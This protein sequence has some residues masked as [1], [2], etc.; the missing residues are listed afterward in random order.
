MTQKKRILILLKFP[1]YGGGSGSFTRNL[2]KQLAKTGEYEVAI[3]APDARKIPGV[4]TYTINPAFKAVFESHPE[5]KRAKRYSQLKGFEFDRQYASFL[6]QIGKIVEDFKPDAIHVNHVHFLTWI[7]SF[8]KSLYGIGFITTVHGT[9]IFNNTIDRRYFVLTRQ[10]VERS[11]QIIAVS[12]HTRKWFLKVFGQKLKYRNRVISNGIDS[13]AYLKR[14]PTKNI[15]KKYG[16]TDKK[17][18]VFVGRLTREKGLQYLIQAAKKIK[19]EIYIIGDGSYKKYLVNY[20]KITGAKNVHFIGY[21]GKDNMN[22]LKEFYQRA[23]VLALPSVVDESL[24]LVVLEA[25]ASWTPVVASK[26]GGIPL[27]VKDGHNGL[28]VRARSAK[29]LSASINKILDNPQLG[30]KLAENAH[31]TIINKFDWKVIMPQYEQAYRKAFEATIKLRKDRVKAIFGRAEIEREK[32]ELT[33]KI[34]IK[35]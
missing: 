24:G 18:V 33:E 19:G 32:R 6:L 28:L 3:A 11:E 2:A 35:W 16:L 13:E 15:D 29:A 12:P 21:F 26:K 23:N 1:L 27:V 9:D 4:K 20:A 31:L 17:L 30:E 10:A 22:E 7:A 34:D 25:M 5:W 14:L 8:I